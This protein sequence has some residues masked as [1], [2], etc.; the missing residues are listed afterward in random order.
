[1][2]ESERKRVRERE[3]DRVKVNWKLDL[4]IYCFFLEP[5]FL[6]NITLNCFKVLLNSRISR[7]IACFKRKLLIRSNHIVAVVNLT[8]VIGVL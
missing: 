1:M 7:H 6:F 3:H 4:F 5:S 2:Q 8:L